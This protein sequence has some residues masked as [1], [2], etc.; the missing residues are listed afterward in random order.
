MWNSETTKY[1]EKNSVLF[2]EYLAVFT[3]KRRPK[4]TSKGEA[5][6][7]QMDRFP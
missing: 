3:M 4:Y 2:D 7:R 6:K 5:A 1:I